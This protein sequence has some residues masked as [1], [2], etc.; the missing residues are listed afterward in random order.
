MSLAATI[1]V[2]PPDEHGNSFITMVDSDGR[3]LPAAEP[4]AYDREGA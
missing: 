2:S 1:L 3:P 4:S